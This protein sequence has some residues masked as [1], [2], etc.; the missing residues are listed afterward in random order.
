MDHLIS[1]PGRPWPP[2]CYYKQPRS[3]DRGGRLLEKLIEAALC[4]LCWRTVGWLFG[5]A[6]WYSTLLCPLQPQNGHYKQWPCQSQ[7]TWPA[8]T[9]PDRSFE[10]WGFPLSWRGCMGM[11]LAVHPRT[12]LNMSSDWWTLIQGRFSTVIRLQTFSLIKCEWNKPQR[13]I[14]WIL[15]FQCCMIHIHWCE[16]NLECTTLGFILS[17]MPWPSYIIDSKCCSCCRVQQLPRS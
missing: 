6:D 15:L 1:W 13:N 12:W 17:P 7:Q 14:L 8:C 9:E 16:V 10:A 4:V 5:Q 2:V 3:C 11:G